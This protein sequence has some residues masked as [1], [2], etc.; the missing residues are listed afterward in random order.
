MFEFFGGIF[1]AWREVAHIS[2]WTG[3]SLGVLAAIALL[4]YLNPTLLKPAIGIGV[5]VIV[6][7][8]TLIFGYH[9]GASD[10]RGQWNAANVQA[11]KAAV[12]RDADAQKQAEAVYKPIIA[13]REQMIAELDQ[14][15]DDYGAQLDKADPCVLGD[16]SLWVRNGTAAA[17]HRAPARGKPVGPPNLRANPQAGSAPAS[18]GANQ[19]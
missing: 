17:P 3:L 6:G 8:C 7:Y 4:V 19:R 18:N 13:A 2:E 11:A 1:A 16:S 12:Q 5:A 15:V 10:I 14:E 9:Q